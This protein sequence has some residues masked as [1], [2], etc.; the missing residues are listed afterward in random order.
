MD[1][2]YELKNI[3][4]L[5]LN[6]D[7]IIEEVRASIIE[8]YNLGCQVERDK[9]LYKMILKAHTSES[10]F[11]ILALEYINNKKTIEINKILF[12]LLFDCSELDFNQL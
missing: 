4:A 2:L 8:Y 6:N 5:Q 9:F 7:K 1:Y 11:Q 10:M 12:D 3:I